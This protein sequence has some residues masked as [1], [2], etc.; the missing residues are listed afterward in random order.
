MP[1]V[2]GLVC[3]VAVMWVVRGALA[4]DSW[5]TLSFARELAEHRHWGMIPGID[6]NTATSPLNVWLLAGVYLLDGRQ[7]V[8]AVGVVLACS[9]AVVGWCG[10]RLV[11]RRGLLAG[12]L[13]V[14]VL[15]SS[16]L[17]V[18]TVGLETYLGA[19]VL[20]SV[21]VA[22]RSGGWW[23]V[24]VLC[25]A[26][27]L[28]RPDLLVPAVVL[29]LG[30]V[31]RRRWLLVFTVGA[32][33]ALPWH[34]WAW[35]RLGGFVPDTLW[36]KVG[37]SAWDGYRFTN[38][39]GLYWRDYPAATAV[40]SGVVVAASVAVVVVRRRLPL[41]LAGAG[42][43]HF[44]VL[45]ALNPSPYPWYYAP[46]FVLCAFALAVVI[47][48]VQWPPRVVLPALAAAV[49][50]CVAGSVLVVGRPDPNVGPVI[51]NWGS[52]A[53]YQAAGQQ[54]AQV[55]G[56]DPVYADTEIGSLAYSCRCDLRNMFTDPAVGDQIIAQRL[57]TAGE[58][59]R[60]LM[61]VNFTF[62]STA[63]QPPY[64]WR[65]SGT[66]AATLPIP[67]RRWVWPASSPVHGANA[68]QLER[69]Y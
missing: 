57:T 50:V 27:V 68:V 13:A 66:S 65:L 44:A 20:V 17:L 41:V 14:A 21:A 38:G 24:G 22:A 55:V 28:T 6:A 49:A 39:V 11:K 51:Y 54:I 42:A 32:A 64:R 9:L 31:A 47:A 12:V 29:V 18:S 33:V 34:L 52:W 7:P 69:I 56:T 61:A 45:M 63:T 36:L 35:W 1:V 26:A 10:S 8:V 67:N 53:Q 48:E 43:A 59:S 58:L 23:W 3:A 60:T 16:P 30:C 25:G 37:E 40:T 4:D 5:I 46:V 19:A 2:F 15:A 62:R